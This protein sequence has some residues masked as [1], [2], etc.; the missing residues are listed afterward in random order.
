M[1][2]RIA[3]KLNN[4]SAHY[5]CEILCTSFCQF[6]TDSLTAS[7]IVELRKNSEVRCSQIP[8][9][10]MASLASI[11]ESFVLV[12]AQ[13]EEFPIVHVGDAF[14]EMTGYSR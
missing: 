2:I 6:S 10:L 7:N 8:T 14:I 12:D 9:S 4:Q 5:P 3:S 1:R 13:N 11:Q